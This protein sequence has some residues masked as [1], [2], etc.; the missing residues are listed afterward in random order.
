MK[1]EEAMKKVWEMACEI[2]K[3][4]NFGTMSELDT[5]AL[6]Y[7]IYVDWDDEGIHVEDDVVYFASWVEA[8][9]EL[10]R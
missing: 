8:H 10:F 5:L 3:T 1:R 2:A 9:P 6:D 4:E 7:E